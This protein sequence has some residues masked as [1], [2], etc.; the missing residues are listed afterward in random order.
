ML[1]INLINLKK[2]FYLI[3]LMVRDYRKIEV[4]RLGYL[5]TLR[6]Y[7]LTDK[8]PEHER[9]NL[10]SQIRRATTSIPLNIAEGTSRFTKRAYLQFLQYGYGSIREL[11]VLLE[12]SKDLGYISRID[13]EEIDEDIDKLSRK[14]FLFLK[15]VEKE[16]FF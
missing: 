10:I 12:L 8:Y 1:L 9:G 15:K 2:V 6:L 5:L 14:L 7:K 4:W 13:Y 11:Q 16:K 3:L